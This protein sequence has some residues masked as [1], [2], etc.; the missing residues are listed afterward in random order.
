MEQGMMMPTIDAH[1]WV[2]RDGQIIDP[3]FSEEDEYIR[4]INK[5]TKEK[6]YHEAPE[7][8]QKVF[9]AIAEKSVDS[10]L[11]KMKMIGGRGMMV[12]SF[13]DMERLKQPM[14]PEEREE[15][16]EEYTPKFGSCMLNAYKEAKKNGG[17]IVFGS[18]GYVKK[19]GGVWWEYGNP[20]W[21]K[22][23]QFKK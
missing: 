10:E 13:F 20:E 1:Y 4:V 19:S 7:L 18:Q 16:L 11:R 5:T 6:K 14:F 8:V 23:S 2:E 12:A 21:N 17:R 22:V 9:L 3:D 15:A